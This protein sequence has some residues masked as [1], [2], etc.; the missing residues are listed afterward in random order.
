MLYQNVR[1]QH[2]TKRHNIVYDIEKLV[3]RIGGLP[4]SIL[5]NQTM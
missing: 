3:P 4:M 2:L 5:C 1:W